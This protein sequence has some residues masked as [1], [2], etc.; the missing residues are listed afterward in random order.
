MSN[1]YYFGNL[2]RDNAPADRQLLEKIGVVFPNQGDR[3]RM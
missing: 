3:A 1:T 2:L